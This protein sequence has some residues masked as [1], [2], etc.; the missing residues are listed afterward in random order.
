MCTTLIRKRATAKKFCGARA[1]RCQSGERAS[2]PTYKNALFHRAFYNSRERTCNRVVDVGDARAHC[3]G[4]RVSVRARHAD[5]ALRTLF[6][7][8]NAAFFVVL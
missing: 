7:K 4:E 1:R 8:W 3:V 2:L 5:N 6:L